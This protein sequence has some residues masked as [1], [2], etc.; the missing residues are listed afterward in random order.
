MKSVLVFLLNAVFTS[1]Y[2][3]Q[4]IFVTQLFKN[5]NKIEFLEPSVIIKK[6]NKLENCFNL[7]LKFNNSLLK[8]ARNFNETSSNAHLFNK[9]ESF[10]QK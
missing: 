4:C 1:I 9:C 5:D 2:G 10:T 7:R 8:N 6:R 3:F